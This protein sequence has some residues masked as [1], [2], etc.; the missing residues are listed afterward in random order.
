MWKK[1]VC[2]PPQQVETLFLDADGRPE[3]LASWGKHHYYLNVEP[4]FVERYIEDCSSIF[5]GGCWVPIKMWDLVDGGGPAIKPTLKMNYPLS[6]SPLVYSNV[7]DLRGPGTAIEEDWVTKCAGYKFVY[8]Q[9]CK[10][11]P[12]AGVTC[13]PPAPEV[14]CYAMSQQVA[15][16]KYPPSGVDLW[17]FTPSGSCRDRTD[18]GGKPHPSKFIGNIN[19]VY[20]GAS[21]LSGSLFCGGLFE[22][23]CESTP[24]PAVAGRGG[25]KDLDTDGDET[26]NFSDLC[27]LL[28]AGPFD[29]SD[30]DG[31][32]VGK[33][34]DPNP[35]YRDTWIGA[36]FPEYNL[37]A[38]KPV[39]G[40]LDDPKRRGWLDTDQD[41]ITNGADFCPATAGG[42]ADQLPN[43]NV[44]AEQSVF[45][46]DP[47][48]SSYV[49]YQDDGKDLSPYRPKPSDAG[50]V[51]RGSLC[52]PYESTRMWQ[53]PAWAAQVRGDV[54]MPLTQ[55][56][57]PT[58]QVRATPLRG[59]SSND[60]AFSGKTYKERLE[61][62]KS[63][64]AAVRVD[65]RRCACSAFDKPAAVRDKVCFDRFTGECPR[66]SPL[67]IEPNDVTRWFAHEFPG[68]A[69]TA[70]DLA[71]GSRC[72]PF[73]TKA[74]V[75]ASAYCP[76][77]ELTG[78][79]K[80]PADLVPKS[81]NLGWDWMIERAKYPGHFRPEWFT[82]AADAFGKGYA[83][84]TVGFT[85]AS[86]TYIDGVVP[87][88]IFPVD[89]DLFAPRA[90]PFARAMGQH[91]D[92]N[93]WLRSDDPS[94]SE[95][96]LSAEDKLR[97]TG[98][99][100]TYF[101]GSFA[102]PAEPH[103][104][105]NKYRPIECVRIYETAPDQTIW[106]MP[107]KPCIPIETCYGNW[108]HPAYALLFSI[109]DPA[110]TKV[111]EVSSGATQAVQV[112]MPQG[113]LAS[114]ACLLADCG[115]PPGGAGWHITAVP[116]STELAGYPKLIA[117]ST[118]P[119]STPGFAGDALGES[120]WVLDPVASQ[121]GIVAY[122]I[123]M[124]GAAPAGTASSTVFLG[125]EDGAHVVAFAEPTAA[126]AARLRVLDLS[127]G[128]WAETPLEGLAARSGASYLL[129]EHGLYRAGGEA[130]GS[131]TGEVIAIDWRSGHFETL[132]AAGTLPARR[133]PALA[134][135]AQGVGLIY[136][137]GASADGAF[138]ND[139]WSL[140][141]G[142]AAATVLV[143]DSA[144]APAT[145]SARSLLVATGVTGEALW[146]DAPTYVVG[147][148][149]RH[150]LRKADLGGWV[151]ADARSKDATPPSCPDGTAPRLC[152]SGAEWWRTPGTRCGNGPCA[153]GR[154]EQA[155]SALLAGVGATHVALEHSTLWIARGS[156]LER[157][158][159]L[160]P[161]NATQQGTLD[162]GSSINAI[163]VRDGTALVATGSAVTRV[164]MVDGALGA[165]S[166]SVPVCDTEGI[167]SLGARGWLLATAGG[168]VLLQP[169]ESGVLVVASEVELRVVGGKWAA[170]PPKQPAKACSKSTGVGEGQPA[171]V[172]FDGRDVELARG[173]DVLRL[174]WD[175]AGQL[176]VSDA[177]SVTG[178]LLA[179]RSA[180]SRAYVV[181]KHPQQKTDL[182]VLLGAS[183][184]LGP[185]HDVASW[186]ESEHSGLYRARVLPDG[187]V[188][189][190][191]L[192]Q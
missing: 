89:S 3:V 49:A 84:A 41:S 56:G 32:G 80:A 27:P 4:Y 98:S 186:V 106:Y 5:I 189:V 50:F 69:R 9:A 122:S 86:R 62:S 136:G 118:K 33:D 61:L 54:C 15:F 11:D 126:A 67:P 146:W 102:Q 45:V 59:V 125:S 142:H 165:L 46:Q 157:W 133:Q 26:P 95:S 128:R 138:H 139:V 168:A 134:W 100:R 169:D 175:D 28:P 104:G 37:R 154:A 55:F 63:K 99:L 167:A 96:K 190:A 144:A 178:K 182:E 1:F 73:A 171:S 79:P 92:V 36:G 191:W 74:P 76:P 110:A 60:L 180:S 21:F 151:L 188:E 123:T 187:R 88:T 108:N 97:R 113:G 47:S 31:D 143:G 30:P 17:P 35:K 181:G 34:C 14:D 149:L 77:W 24:L 101:S 57:T 68:C 2:N 82:S 44:W 25:E 152:A 130:A 159:L 179:V 170:T 124:Q 184:T 147:E 29:H 51:E 172:A 161:G 85:F 120:Y 19:F 18:P 132:V 93:P 87:G 135:D 22:D 40:A 176:A 174:R 163:A 119:P 185:K 150:A 162:L 20:F 141:S 64:G 8:E 156:K 81:H 7:G 114:L 65:P 145:L 173:N 121:Q 13:P 91:A 158:S 58:I 72:L 129:N 43:W 66:R 105:L 166:T 140:R 148:G 16:C 71:G 38:F 6:T 127:D 53:E 192:A 52:D 117:V 164:A 75:A 90:Q 111:V 109:A 83:E 39:Q 137:G 94:K 183:M 12:A 131:L 112:V 115:P 70:S 10:C 160:E 107:Y 116:G 42:T 78:C 177:V 153:L 23:G 48:N 155:S 103:I